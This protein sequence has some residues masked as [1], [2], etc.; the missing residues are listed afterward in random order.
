M[1]VQPPGH[2]RGW[3]RM[4]NTWEKEEEEL[5]SEVGCGDGAGGKEGSSDGVM[6]GFSVLW[7]QLRRVN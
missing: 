6:L 1:I 7:R 3:V 5:W 2:L 4:G